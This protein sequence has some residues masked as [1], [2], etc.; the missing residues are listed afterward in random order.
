M[1]KKILLTIIIFIS[2]PGYAG[3]M[4][5][6]RVDQEFPEAMT[7]LQLAV[8]GHGYTVSRVQ[9]V[10]IGLESQGY[11]TDKY[12][13][14]FFGKLEEIKRITE[15]YPLMI[16]N[17]PVSVS[18]FAED[19]FTLLVALNPVVFKEDV[20]DPELQILFDRWESDLHSIFAE[21]KRESED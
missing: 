16:A 12:R 2:S 10:D 18:I 1:F 8:K 20:D 9:R 6:L 17:L 7:S 15:A 11:T 5:M 13:V 14:V 3:E 4:I 19:G 21:V